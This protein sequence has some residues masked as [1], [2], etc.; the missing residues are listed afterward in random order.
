VFAIPDDHEPMAAMAI[1]HRGDPAALPEDLRMR[2][3]RARQR[4][5][6]PEF[7]FGGRFGDTAGFVQVGR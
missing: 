2:E 7:V 3:A 5:P 6:L 4:R 1:G